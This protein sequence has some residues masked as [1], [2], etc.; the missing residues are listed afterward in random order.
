MIGVLERPVAEPVSAA[1][2]DETHLYCCD[3]DR[4]RCGKDITDEPE[5]SGV[6]DE[7]CCPLCVIW[8]GAPCGDPLCPWLDLEAS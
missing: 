4:S 7:E 5:V 8:Q 1:A 3:P 6:P 2:D